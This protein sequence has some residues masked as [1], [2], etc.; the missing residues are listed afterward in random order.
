M[1]FDANAN[2]DLMKFF[3]IDLIQHVMWQK[4]EKHLTNRDMSKIT[5]LFSFNIISVHCL[6]YLSRGVFSKSL[7]Y[8]AECNWIFISQC[9]TV[10]HPRGI[11]PCS[12]LSGNIS[13][14]PYTWG[15]FHQPMPLHAFIRPLSIQCT[16]GI[17]HLPTTLG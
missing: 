7:Y 10:V 5:N 8:Q 4:K 15:N 11:F 9:S 17:F 2:L 1:I 13:I 6:K 3:C 16:Y 14:S 12:S